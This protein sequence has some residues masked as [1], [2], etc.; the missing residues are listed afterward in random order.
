MDQQ[1]NLIGTGHL[2]P[3]ARGRLRWLVYGLAAG[4]TT[5]TLLI[6]L[7]L[8][9]WI[10]DSRPVLVL[11]LI[12]I[13]VSAYWGGLGPGLV[14]TAVAAMGADFFL[15]PPDHSFAFAGPMEFAQWLIFVVSG[16]LASGMSEA[17]HR[18]RR[19]AEANKQLLTVTLRSIGDAVITTDVRG[20]VTFLNQEAERLTGW[21][22]GDATGQ[23]LANVFRIVNQETREPVEDPV[24]KVLHSNAV[25]G[26][27]NHTVLISRN[28]GEYIIDDSGA[29]IRQADGRIIGVVLVFRDNTTKHQ[30]EDLLLRN[31]RFLKQTGHIAQVG[32]WEFDPATGAG[33]WGEEV[34]RIHDLDLHTQPN[35][36]MGFSFYHGE[37]REKIETAVKAAIEHGTPYDLELEIVSAKGVRKWVRTI[38]QPL[39]ENGKVLRVCGAMQDI[40]QWRQT[41]AALEETQ[42]LHRSLV[43]QLPAGVFRK[44]A[45]G[46]YVFVNALF[47]RL[48]GMCPEQ[49]LG[50]TAKEIGLEDLALAD[51]GVS[52]HEQILKTGQQIEADETLVHSDGRTLFFHA[53]KTPVFDPQ[54]KIIG[55]QGVLFD[56]TELKTTQ[57]R[58]H[59]EHT[60]L[61]TLMDLAPDFIFVKDV[62]SRFLVVNAAL[63]SCYGQTPATMLGRTDADFMPADQATRCRATELQVLA[64][65]SF[66]TIKGAVTYPDGRPRVVVTNMVAFTDRQ[67]KVAGLVGIGRDATEQTLAENLSLG[68][69]RVLDMM[70]H[71]QP[72]PETLTALLE[73]IE[74]R[75]PDMYCSILLLEADGLRLRHGAAPRLPAVYTEALNGVTIGPNVGSC[76]T[77][78]FRQEPVFVENIATDPLWKDFKQ[79]A[80]PHG[81]QACWSTPIFNEQKRLLGT[82]AVYHQ[83]PGRP[84][85][86]QL[87][88]IELATDMAAICIGRHR[89]ET[90]LRE[91]EARL[92]TIFQSSPIGILITR[93]N[94]GRILEANAAFARIHECTVE[95]LIGR[96]ASELG[97]WA[98]LQQRE[99][100][101][102]ILNS[103]GRCKDFEIKFRKKDGRIG[104]LLISSELIELAGE[105][106]M[107]GLAS[108]ITQEKLAREQFG[109]DQARFKLIF[110][111][112]PVG[113]AFH[114]IHPD[115]S[116]TRL[117][118][119]AHLQICGLTREQSRELQ[120][121]ITITHP[122]EREAQK[123][124]MGEITA[125]Q[126]QRF[127][128][129]RRYVHPD[130]SVVWVN[131]SF[132]RVTQPDGTIEELTTVVDI[133]ERKLAEQKL[134]QLAVI[135]ESSGDA[136]IS[137]TL[138]GII[139]SWNRGAENLFGYAA[140][141][142]IG[143]SMLMLFPAERLNE[144]QDIL[145]RIARGE[146]VDHFE[147]ERVRKDGKHIRISTTISPL[148]DSHG[149]IVGASKIARD[150]TR[151]HQLEEQLRQSQKME[152]IGQ[153][154]GGV[155]HDFNNI[156]AVIQMQLELA[157]IEGSFGPE[158][159]ECLDE[160]QIAANRAANLTRQLLLFSR[161]NKLQP[162]ALDL[163][164]SITSM[165][166]MLRRILG[167]DIL[168]H[169]KFASQ[170]L[171][172]H[173]DPGMVDQVV[174]N[175]AINSRDAMPNGGD[176]FIETTT[177]ELDELAARQS[178]RARP[179]SFVCLTMT[180]TGSG[181][182]DEILPRIFE[183]FFT[184]KGVGKG[185]GL[186]LATVFGIVAQH[187]GWVDVFSEVGQGTT[188]RIFFPRLTGASSRQESVKS[189]LHSA[190]QGDEMILLVE[191]DAA[192]RL[193]FKKALTQ[194]GYQVVE[195]GDAADAD[196]LW[197]QYRDQI[198]LL[199]TDLVMPGRMNGKE[200]AQ[201]LLAESSELKV[202]YMSGYSPDIT[203]SDLHLGE[204]VCFLAK[205][206]DTFTLAQT[207]RAALQTP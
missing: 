133:T 189:V 110:D 44:D 117:V 29:P 155:A 129:E 118:N 70:A 169:F 74:A 194:L 184:T 146:T 71:G 18:A 137:K 90:S 104:D 6:R 16:V 52:H 89:A 35:K 22:T 202:I 111:T 32:G 15:I 81:L 68:Q 112:M 126:V 178:P 139:T 115:G 1:P 28:G 116:V 51:A 176:L 78:A 27:A 150:I 109:R 66:C 182:P 49:F 114:T 36:E 30:A 122:A 82:F 94:D 144:E 64:A 46:R 190:L 73:T 173:A 72:L 56:V 160:I 77:A 195:A 165:T 84:N 88:L 148:L 2:K 97:L 93:F 65:K 86:Q 130:A 99:R 132:Q 12:P 91:S 205:P 196:A 197:N 131:L 33:Q 162:R 48:K 43:E 163:S 204:G 177:V 105:P 9:P 108:D 186:G 20:A 172:I 179:G 62:E 63:A 191:D 50:K 39:I 60:L 187:H 121:Y 67:G 138:D 123:K 100:M 19:Q 203:L 157:K 37:S 168:M 206:F 161:R 8:S 47:C 101:V 76:G 154:A 164:D 185:T 170:P 103:E 98:D 158:Q 149:K 167:E 119:D 41:Q 45:A 80:L 134:R 174:M 183:P 159:M 120:N 75:D 128:L 180:D 124:M 136:I 135:V 42:A 141:E 127:S 58:Y 87:H 193:A 13:L 14:A 54:G 57:T 95:E 17:L 7:G 4:M 107:L 23:P 140:A 38:C 53:V 156:L 147:T 106:C 125:N 61:R 59:A 85:A 207:I 69:K 171:L 34:A 113:I 31:K 102:Q 5:L 26:L 79:L 10:G 96:T 55:S 181:I 21:T 201:R 151:Q 145:A 25:V 83:Q 200:F 152:A 198:K 24:K 142:T 143:Q 166:K 40:T 92:S 11:F 175:L 192:L 3:S 153:L 188:F 199:L